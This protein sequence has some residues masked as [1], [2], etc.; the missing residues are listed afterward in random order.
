M[1]TKAFIKTFSLI[2]Y[3]MV[4]GVLL[5]G[6][7]LYYVRGDAFLRF[8]KTEEDMLF[9][10]SPMVAAAGIVF[11]RFLPN[12]IIKS[13]SMNTEEEKLGGFK[14]YYLIKYALLEGAGLFNVIAFYLSGNSLH[15]LIAAIM[16]LLLYIEK[17]T[18]EKL[19]LFLNL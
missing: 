17:P 6:L 14:V 18:E 13:R 12:L 4:T 8:E 3:A 15:L 16:V 10:I 1:E 2:H 11:S 7:A 19:K 9:F 5:C